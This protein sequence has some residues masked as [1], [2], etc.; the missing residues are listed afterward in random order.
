MDYTPE[1][2][3]QNRDK[4]IAGL[5]SGKYKQ[6][7]NYMKSRFPT[8]EGVPEE[9]RYCCLGVAYAEI[10]PD[11]ALPL[12]DKFNHDNI[13]GVYEE[14]NRAI[15]NNVQNPI[16]FVRYND[17]QGLTFNQI[18]NEAKKAWNK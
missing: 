4:M 2:I 13:S 16:P 3:S 7:R 14:V 5:L 8:S 11:R 15:G 1:Q 9:Y 18:A 6:G 12:N 10:F 17:E